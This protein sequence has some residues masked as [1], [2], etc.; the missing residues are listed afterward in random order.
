[1][2]QSELQGGQPPSH[3]ATPCQGGGCGARQQGAAATPGQA[4]PRGGLAP[5]CR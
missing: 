5:A 3:A 1:M 4:E 2:P